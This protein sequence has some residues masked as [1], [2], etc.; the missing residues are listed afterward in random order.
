MDFLPPPRPGPRP[1][2][3]LDYRSPPRGTADVA[4][5]GLGLASFTLRLLGV[6]AIIIG[7]L[8]LLSLFAGIDDRRAIDWLFRRGTIVM[9]VGIALLLLSVIVH[10]R[11]ECRR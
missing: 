10:R 5:R 8:I 7:L 6:I 11:W 4:A 9:G 1:P 2:Q 3:P